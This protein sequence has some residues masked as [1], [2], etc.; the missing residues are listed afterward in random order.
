M[1]SLSESFVIAVPES[2]LLQVALWYHSRWQPKNSRPGI[3]EGVVGLVGNT[4]LVRI[5][6][7]SEATGCEASSSRQSPLSTSPHKHA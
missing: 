1:V 4:P 7:L 5:T 3:V 6:S 2:A